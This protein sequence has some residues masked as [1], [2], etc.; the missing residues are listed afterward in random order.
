[1]N[2]GQFRTRVSSVIGLDTGV[3]T[4][5]L[6]LMDDWVNEAV[7]D[8]LTRTRCTVNFTTMATTADQWQYHLDDDIIAIKEMWRETSGTTSP[9]MTQVS[10]ADILEYRRASAVPASSYAT[11]WA[12]EGANLLLLYPTPSEAYNL[13]LHYVPRP[14]A[15]SDVSDDPS[16][17]TF[18]RI[19][20]EYHPALESYALMKAADY[21]DDA[22]SQ[23]GDRYRRDYE[24]HIARIKREMN[25]KTGVRLARARR[26]SGLGRLR[27]HDP[28]TDLGY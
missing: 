4:T 27:T 28:S 12:V 9:V 18:G 26:P 11:Y 20:T 19:P 5:E 3:G 14:T 10:P 16:D 21:A 17:S 7:I 23:Q 13:S 8:L 24:Q 6:D 2:L 15:L 22:S 1:M 25:T